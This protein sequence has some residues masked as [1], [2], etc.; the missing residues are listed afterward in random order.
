MLTLTRSPKTPLK[1]E[2]LKKLNF[3]WGYYFGGVLLSIL[4]VS[5]SLKKK[6]FLPLVLLL[7]SFRSLLSFF[8]VIFSFC[9]LFCFVHSCRHSVIDDGLSVAAESAFRTIS[10]RYRVGFDS[11]A[12]SS[13]VLRPAALHLNF[14][15]VPL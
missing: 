8:F 6:N 4:S 14:A 1:L 12:V 10:V 13:G 7:F 3:F 15:G 5:A 2:N 11:C 9:F